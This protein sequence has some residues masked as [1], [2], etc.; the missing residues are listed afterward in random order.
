[1]TAGVVSRVSRGVTAVF[2]LLVAFGALPSCAS[3]GRWEFDGFSNGVSDGA[4]PQLAMNES[5]SAVLVFR[6][7]GIRASFRPAGGAGSGW[8]FFYKYPEELVSRAGYNGAEAPVAAID[9]A[10]DVIVAWE[11]EAGGPRSRVFAAFKPVGGSFSVPVALSSEAAAAPSVAMDARGDATV[12]WLL[13]DGTSEIVQA[14]TASMGGS[15]S[16][17]IDLSGDGANAASAQ[18]AMDSNGDTVA[19]WTRTVSANSE[20]EVAVRRTGNGFSA[21][22]LHG[23]GSIV[24]ESEPFP[25]ESPECQACSQEPRRKVIPVQHVALDSSGEAV[26]VWRTSAGAVE[27][28]RLPARGSSFGAPE[29]LGNT[30]GIPWVAIDEAGEAVAVWSVALGVD[31]AILA[32][33]SV[34]GGTV[35]FASPGGT[36]DAPKVTM[37]AAGGTAVVWQTGKPISS[38][39]GEIDHTGVF[40]PPGGAFGE[41]SSGG[42]GGGGAGGGITLVPD[43]LAVASDV[44]GDVLGVWELHPEIGDLNTFFYDTGPAFSGVSVPTSGLAGQPLSFSAAEPVSVWKPLS[45]VMWSFGDGASASGLSASH[46]YTQPGAYQVTVT[47]RDTQTSMPF[48]EDVAN[49]ITRT[50]TISAAPTSPAS[51]PPDITRVAQSHKRW[52]AGNT[53]ART[54]KGRSKTKRAKPPLGTTFS[55]TLNEQASVTLTFTQQVPGRSVKGMCAALTRQ[56]RRKRSCERTVTPGTLSFT[57]HVGQNEIRFQGRISSSEQLRPGR[58]TLLIIAT[59]TTGQRS[60]PKRLRFTVLRATGR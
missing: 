26:M 4:G 29:T 17:P 7:S 9:A 14:A 8:A 40:R 56:N 37:G 54:S 6:A 32:P 34:F 23:D 12:M 44:V 15:F 52:R 47:A 36:P 24:G 27:V 38:Q 20:L 60:T 42:E 48:H 58:Y 16:A 11:E 13:D 10:G 18:V 1:M 41:P 59:N 2:A 57:G 5:G 51:I 30:P 50:V 46:A 35:Q 43:S 22:D 45:S 19:S 39:A 33:G 53:L 21:P 28:A 25:A 31:A 49:S 3:A 55:F